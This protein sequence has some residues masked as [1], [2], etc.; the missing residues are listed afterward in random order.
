MHSRFSVIGCGIVAVGIA[1][2]AFGWRYWYGIP[3]VIG[4]LIVAMA[5]WNIW[6]VNFANKR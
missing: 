3:A 1:V 2:A 5:A 4:L 6:A